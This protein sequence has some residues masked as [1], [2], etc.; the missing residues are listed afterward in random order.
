[1]RRGD[2]AQRT[3]YIHLA[4]VPDTQRL[5]EE[6]FKS[7]FKRAHADIL[8][9]LCSAASHGLRTEK[10]LKLRALPRLAT[11]YR[12]ASACE[13]ALWAKGIFAR[14]F[15]ANAQDATEDIIEG[16][17]AVAEFRC[18]MIELG[19]WEGTATDLLAELVAFVRRLVRKAEAEHAEAVKE[20]KWGDEAK[21][22][23]TAAA[24]REAR[25]KAR[26]ILG[27]GWPKLPHLLAGRLKR[28]SPALRKTGIAIEWP[29]RHGSVKIIKVVVLG[30]K[31]RRHKASQ[32]S[33][34]EA[35]LNE[36]NTLGGSRGDER[37]PKEDASDSREGRSPTMR[38]RDACEI[39]GTVPGLGP[40]DRASR[41]NPLET[42][43]D[44]A[45]LADRDG[46][47]ASHPS[48]LGPDPAFAKRDISEGEL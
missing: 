25:E 14:A 35:A 1:M 8:G 41:T 2:L 19:G 20:G 39:D 28:A 37:G 12:W 47:D 30:P 22:E 18:R 17:K 9:S 24:L 48:I 40:P 11:F 5:T 46:W 15:E 34:K 7:R 29:T 43:V 44:R 21:K 23:K 3:L 26:D 42:K 27:E 10:T 31:Q 38:E 36:F 4:T 32:A 33:Q 16:D 45:S 13:G 6:E